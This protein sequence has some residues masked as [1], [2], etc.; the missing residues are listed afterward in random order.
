MAEF[1]RD[2][3][4]TAAIFGFFAS[5]WFGWAQ[6]D[7][8][9]TWKAWLVSGSL[10]GLMVAILGGLVAWQ[11]WDTGTVFDRTTSISFGIVVAIE[12]VIAA[13]GSWILIRRRHAD[14]VG[15]WVAFVVGAHFIPL[16]VLLQYPLFYVVAIALMVGSPIAVLVA[17]RSSITVSAVNGVVAGSILLTAALVSLAGSLLA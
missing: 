7:P 17:R 11:N 2:A 5:A 15:P 3:A 13:L 8:P 12:V 10:G 4:M 1:I 16:A 9:R 6:E 14:L